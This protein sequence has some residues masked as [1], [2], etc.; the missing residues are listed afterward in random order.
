MRGSLPAGVSGDEGA[1]Y[2]QWVP[3]CAGSKF[4]L[5]ACCVCALPHAAKDCIPTFLYRTESTETA[6]DFIVPL[7]VHFV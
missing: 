5:A 1:R 6:L 2:A 4:R 7:P 3:H